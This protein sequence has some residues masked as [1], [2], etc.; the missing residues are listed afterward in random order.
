MSRITIKF[1]SQCDLSGQ[2]LG[3]KKMF[4]ALTADSAIQA[5]DQDTSVDLKSIGLGGRKV[6]IA[7]NRQK[8]MCH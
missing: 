4:L 3:K 5:E 1:S 2:N 7:Q 6:V 8:F